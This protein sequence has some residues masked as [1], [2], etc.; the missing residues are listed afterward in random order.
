MI[1]RVKRRFGGILGISC[2]QLNDLRG[3][4]KVRVLVKLGC[5]ERRAY[6]ASGRLGEEGIVLIQDG[7]SVGQAWICGSQKF[8]HTPRAHHGIGACV[9]TVCIVDFV[10]QSETVAQF[11]TGAIKWRGDVDHGDANGLR[12]AIPQRDVGEPAAEH[13]SRLGIPDQD[14]V[15]RI[16]V[17]C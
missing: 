16:P 14:N 13:I 5:H 12:A 8:N 3:V 7:Q 17:R 11:L 10:L 9:F 6:H 15:C 2:G 4:A 1:E